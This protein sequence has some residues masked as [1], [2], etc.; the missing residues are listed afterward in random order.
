M[1]YIKSMTRTLN[2]IMTMDQKKMDI[3]EAHEKLGH[4]CERTTRITVESYGYKPSETVETEP[5]RK[6]YLDTKGT[7]SAG[8]TKYDSQLVDQAMGDSFES[9]K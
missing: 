7:Q 8:G 9:K 5:G 4:P 1:W 3:N 6:L 2:K